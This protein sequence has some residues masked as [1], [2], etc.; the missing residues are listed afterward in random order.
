M[1]APLSLRH[2][3]KLLEIAGDVVVRF[4]E[5]DQYKGEAGAL[6]A[7]KRRAPGFSDDD[8]RAAFDLMSRVLDRAIDAIGRHRVH[9]PDKKSRFSEPED[10]DQDACM[11]ELETIEPGVA[12]GEKWGMLNWA[13]FWHYLK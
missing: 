5:H 9:R 13:I 10:I 1:D 12:T 2:D 8:C 7:L 6:K 4:K 3:P 11:R